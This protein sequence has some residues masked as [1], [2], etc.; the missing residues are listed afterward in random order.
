[1]QQLAEPELEAVLAHEI[2]HYRKKHIPKRLVASAAGSLLGFFLLGLLARQ[3]W[4]YRAFGF[5]A[6][7]A[8]PALLLFGLLG[9]VAT[10]W[11]TPLSHWWSR[12]NE[13]EAD[14]FA[15]TVMREEKSLIGALRKL[16]KENL[17]N[18]TPHPIY[19]R[20]HYSHP[21]L[22]EREAALRRAS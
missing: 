19:S 6:G 14:A 12:L 13:Y 20:F 10:F 8:A 9:G 7:H 16:N 4:F 17:S 22:L 21:T 11:L 1:T 5:E 15:A 3:E 18:L 2:G